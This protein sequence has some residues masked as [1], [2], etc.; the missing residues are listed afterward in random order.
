MDCTVEDSFLSEPP[1]VL[2]VGYGGAGAVV[3]LR[4]L[5]L[6]SS[7]SGSPDRL[8]LRIWILSR[9]NPAHSSTYYAQG[10]IAVVVEPEDT[11]ELHI[12]DTLR[13]GDG[14][15]DPGVVSFIVREGPRA[16]QW[17]LRLGISFDRNVETGHLELG[18]EGGHTRSRI[19]HVRDHTGRDLLTFLQDQIRSWIKQ[20]IVQVRED[21]YILRLLPSPASRDN[22]WI[23][24]FLLRD[25]TRI[26]V[27]V[28]CVVLATGGASS[29]Y[30]WTT[31]PPGATGIGLFL[32][33]MAEIPCMDVEF[34]QFHPTGLYQPDED[35][36]S[37]ITEALRGAGARLLSYSS[38][39]PF[40]E[41]YEPRWKDLA[42]RDR[43]A[44]AIVREMERERAPHVWLDARDVLTPERFPGVY[45]LCQRAGIDPTR[46]LI[47]VHP[48]A[49]YM[50]G[51]IWTD[52]RGC[53]WFP[54]LFAVGEC[55]R[56]GLHGANRLA[57][58]SLL[59]LLV[60][61]MHVA[62]EIARKIR[63]SFQCYQPG[64]ILRVD[65]WT[66]WQEVH[67][68]K[69]EK[70]DW[71][72]SL[73]IEVQQALGVIK[74]RKKI[75]SLLTRLRE[76]L[77]SFPDRQEIQNIASLPW[78]DFSEFRKHSLLQVIRMIAEAS[79]RRRRNAGCFYA[80][81]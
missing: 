30:R 31:N 56:T 80:E 70:R 19:V 23:V 29:I 39:Q 68:W 36:Q 81:E 11:P 33:W 7:E 48:V 34:I 66:P 38:Q 14:I 22:G 49:H 1:H 59:E 46:E 65:T 25:G 12:A 64:R 60:T 44:R 16:L 76:E 35:P 73:R 20:G 43:V 28:P 3:A 21:A 18:M 41:R 2:I 75:R 74:S 37:L 69:G 27:E 4:L 42:P 32:A 15:C 47:P 61:G 62:E 52:S 71:W 72:N 78:R 5:H 55:A 67:E 40:M 53:T 63:K 13:A 45:Q 50:C 79:L 6:L 8:P 17:L 10:G 58:N 54:G 24:D 9:G 51:G 26:Q 57:S 77:A